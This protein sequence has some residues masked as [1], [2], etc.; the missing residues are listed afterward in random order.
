MAQPTQTLSKLK[1]SL[2]TLRD[3]PVQ[4]GQ[5]RDRY[6]SLQFGRAVIERKEVVVGIGIAVSPSFVMEQPRAP[7][8]LRIIGCDDSAFTGCDVLRLLQAEAADMT[9]GAHVFPFV[10]RVESLGA[11][12]DD[13]KVVFRREF[14]DWIH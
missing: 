10:F 6:R 12:L 5:L 7:G 8:V 14:H 3:R 9:D 11:I 4:L 1:G 2:L 13:Y